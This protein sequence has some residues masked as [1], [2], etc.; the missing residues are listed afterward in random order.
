M[1]TL[2]DSWRFSAGDYVCAKDDPTHTGRV[3]YIRWSTI[4]VVQ[5]TKNGMWSELSLDECDLVR[6]VRA[7]IERENEHAIRAYRASAQRAS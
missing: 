6:R 2:T 3:H 5:W 4:A 7:P 1:T